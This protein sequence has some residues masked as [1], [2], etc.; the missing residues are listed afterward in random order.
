MTAGSMQLPNNVETLR[1]RISANGVGWP[2]LLGMLL[3]RSLLFTF[4]QAVIA[5]LLALVAGAANP[6]EASTAWWPWSAAITGL[7]MIFLLASLMRREGGRLTDLYRGDR[8]FWKS[9]L[10]VL[11]GFGLI[12]GPVA[13]L[14]NYF[15]TIWLYGDPQATLP[16]FFR[17]LPLW[18]ALAG[19]AL[20]P[21]SVALTELPTYFGYVMP[22]LQALTGSRWLAVLLPAFFLGAQH[23]FLPLVFDVRFFAWRFLMYMPFALLTGLVLQWRPR[24]MPYIM[25]FHF[26]IDFSL[27]AYIIPAAFGM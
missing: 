20:F 14:P 7:V 15:L 18:A 11:L 26:L 9:D 6:W 19:S 23:A 2:A 1:S 21:L 22:R 17:P 8:R 16:L 25:A 4:F 5:I 27:A 12:C 10:L 13:M 24:L 3:S